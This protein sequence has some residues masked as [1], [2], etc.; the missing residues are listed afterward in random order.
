MK[1]NFTYSQVY[2][3]MLTS[4]SRKEF[5]DLEHLETLNYKEK[6]SNFWRKYEIKIIK[7]IE[8][9]SKLKFKSNKDC[10]IV[11][12]M[13]YTAISN[14]LT[15]RRDGDLL[16]TRA[17]LIHELIHI[18]LTENSNKVSKL[19]EKSYPGESKD[20]KIHIPVL[21]ITRKVL[22]NLFGSKEYEKI[23]N[24]DMHLDGLNEIWPTVNSIYNKFN[25]DIVKFLKNEKLN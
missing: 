16:T 9:V 4:M 22:E 23:L 5:N 15:I 8:N 7:E 13:K 24:R 25:N 14:P 21:L 11:S 10:Y 1:I 20:F 3:E 19:I 17:T 18:L 12:H 2:D 6:F